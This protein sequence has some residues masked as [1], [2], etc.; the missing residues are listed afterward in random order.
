[1]YKL[2]TTIALI[3]LLLLC[4]C[5]PPA[6][7]SGN[8]G[9]TTSQTQQ[10]SNQATPARGQQ[11]VVAMVASDLGI[12]DGVRVRELDGLLANLGETQDIG[13]TLY[14]T[15]PQQIEFGEID[16]EVGM[17]DPESKLP[18]KM[19][20]LQAAALLDQ[21]QSCDWLVLSSGYLLK[22]ALER[23]DNGSL[24]AKAVIVVDEIGSD[25][26]IN[27]TSVPVFRL[28]FDICPAAF[29]AGAAAAR[30]SN[31]A[32][33]MLLGSADDPQVAEFM[34]AAVA[35]L[36]YVS[37]SAW[38]KQAV[39]PVDSR[40]MVAPE[41][42]RDEHI[43]LLNE[44]G[45]NYNGNHYILDLT[46]STPYVT[47]L[48]A[49][50]QGPLNGYV[51]GGYEDLR[52]VAEKRI[53]TFGVKKGDVALAWLLKNCATVAD[54]QAAADPNGYIMFGLKGSRPGLDESAVGY[55]SLEFYERYNPDGPDIAAE[56]ETIWR[57][58]E[59]GELGVDYCDH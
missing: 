53:L 49:D 6:S 2:S 59:A 30:S 26:V 54:L 8:T 41:T 34:D 10:G 3:S 46:R 47:A 33:F 24:K 35:G 51:S 31:V 36:E 19:T 13:Y 45:A 48:I 37:P 43:R 52:H 12:G 58:L 11:Q 4:G 1:M 39:L 56:L 55:T 29:M 27:I 15:L 17:P 18:G 42:F 16:G 7:K 23:I 9:N 21:V 20:D 5:P 38:V 25:G 32:H 14:G 22:S 40:G 44:A 57:E 50:P 28:R